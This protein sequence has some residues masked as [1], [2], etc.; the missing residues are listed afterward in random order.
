[1]SLF[2]NDGSVAAFP[3]P[4][5]PTQPECGAKWRPPDLTADTCLRCGRLCWQH[6][7]VRPE[8]SA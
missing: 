3:P 5:R 2:C 6:W 1:M 7:T 8:R 4:A